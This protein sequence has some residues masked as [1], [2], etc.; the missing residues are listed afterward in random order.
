MIVIC[1]TSPI[2]NLIQIGYLELLNKLYGKVLIPEGVYYELS[3]YEY[4]GRILEEKDWIVVRKVIDRKEVETLLDYLDLGECE[5]IVLAK[6]SSADLLIMDERKGRNIAKEQGLEIIGLLGV[7]VK[8]RRRGYFEKLKPILD[9]LIDEVGFRVS[10]NLYQ[11][12]LES[13]G[14][15]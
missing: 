12:I 13:V 3:E 5:A 6:E 1:D 15:L 7:L 8:G 10:R 4:H 11:K 9:E 14:E 2:T